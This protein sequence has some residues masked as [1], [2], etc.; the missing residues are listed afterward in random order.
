MGKPGETIVVRIDPDLKELIPNYLNNRQK[1]MQ[2]VLAALNKKDFETIRNLGHSM[3][4]SGGGYG[5]DAI[6]QIGCDLEQAAREGKSEG[7]M[8]SIDELGSYLD[9]VE[10]VSE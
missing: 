4:G 3:K 7:I 9:R 2:A 10:V 1:D 8:K 5:F 6:S